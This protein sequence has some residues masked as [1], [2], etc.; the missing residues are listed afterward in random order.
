MIEQPRDDAWS[1]IGSKPVQV[2]ATLNR[3]DLPSPAGQD[4]RL[5]VDEQ[6]VQDQTVAILT[7]E[8]PDVDFYRRTGEIPAPVMDA[9]AKAAALKQATVDTQAQIDRN[10]AEQS[11]IT[12]E[13]SRLRDNIKAVQPSSTYYERL[14]KKLDAQETRIDE[15]E[16]ELGTWQQK[17]SGQQQELSNYLNGLNVG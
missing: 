3:F 5:R 2:T 15:L 10:K 11:D 17:L 4:A 13:Q 12:A 6:Q 8:T 14:M 1:I 9:L 16:A 7:M